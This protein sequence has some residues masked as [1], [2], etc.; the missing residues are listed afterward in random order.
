LSGELPF[1]NPPLS[2]TELSFAKDSGSSARSRSRMRRSRREFLKP[3]AMLR[4]QR[5]PR[6]VAGGRSRTRLPVIW[7]IASPIADWTDVARS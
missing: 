6:S 4:S 3:A 5:Q 2:I 7:N 1:T